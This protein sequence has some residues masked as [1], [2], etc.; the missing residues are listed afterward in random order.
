MNTLSRALRGLEQQ[1]EGVIAEVRT[2]VREA[3]EIE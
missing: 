2:R 3:A 1:Y